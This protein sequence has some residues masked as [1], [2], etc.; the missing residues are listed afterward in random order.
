MKKIRK[1]GNRVKIGHSYVG[2]ECHRGP[3]IIF[4]GKLNQ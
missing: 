1:T 4:K 3:E 2:P